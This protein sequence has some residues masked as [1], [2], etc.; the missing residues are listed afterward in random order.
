VDSTDPWANGQ[1]AFEHTLATDTPSLADARA[2]ASPARATGLVALFASTLFLSAFLSFA[3]EPMVAKMVLPILGGAPMVWNSCVMFFQMALLAG[4]G[5]AYGASRQQNVRRQ[6]TLHAGLLLIPFVVLPIMID[7]SSALPPDGN[8]VGWL[9]VLLAGTIGLPFLV[10]SSTASM[11]Q[12]WFSRTNH[13]AARDPYF[14]YVASNLGSLLAL[15]SYPVLMEP[16]LT[17]GA[18][19]RLWAGGYAVFVAL[20]G[21]CA[22]T[23]SRQRSRAPTSAN[24]EDDVHSTRESN[25]PVSV[26]RRARWVAASFVPSSLML[27]V[28]SYLSTDIASVPLLWILPLALYLLTFVVAFSSKAGQAQA[29][30]RRA[31]PLLVV[32]LV[33]LMTTRAYVPLWMVLPLHLAAFVFVG[34]L[35]HGELACDRPSAAHLTEFYFWISLGGMLG[36]TFNTL[37]APAIFSGIGEYPLALVLACLWLPRLDSAVASDRAIALDLALPLATGVLTAS[38]LV[39]IGSHELG[40]SMLVAALACPALA[41]YGLKRRPL[42]FAF[43]LGAMLLAGSWFAGDSVLHRSRTFFGVYRVSLDRSGHHRQLV[44]GTTLHGMQAL[45]PASRSE[46]L[47]YYHRTGPF[48]QALAKLPNRVTAQHIAVIGLGVGT[49]AAYVQPGQQWTFFEIDPEVERIARTSTYFTYLDTCQSQCRVVLGDARLSLARD[50]ASRYDLIVLDAFSSDAIPVHL[51]TR[52]ALSLYVSRLAPGGAL[53][54]HISNTHL[55]LG[56]IVARLAADHGLVAVDQRERITPD[57]PEGKTAS[58]WSILAR[59]AADLGALNQDPRW[60]PLVATGT[61][62][63]WTDDFSNIVSVLN[64]SER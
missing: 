55:S 48:G 62:P 53:A 25:A 54:F 10:L 31:V 57:W 30:A 28:T 26:A 38:S 7:R 64:L 42:R 17:L 36:G 41:A 2:I 63:L 61:V 29:L 8:P 20:T 34:L 58:H 49:L 50:S 32:T 35:C 56:P 16:L 22:L 52:E 37:I 60:A 4:Y 19:S 39:W 46:P 18:Q 45:E 3:A 12:L 44:H 11:L 47:T 27:A 59:S 40:A 15:A 9:L 13:P 21:A 1:L 51:L 33:L 23:S 14:L 6:L 24:E 5:Y 43:S